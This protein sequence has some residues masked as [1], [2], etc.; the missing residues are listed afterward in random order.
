[1]DYVSSSSSSPSPVSPTR[2]AALKRSSRSERFKALLL[3]KGGRADFSSRI[4]A[5]ERLRLVPSPD[6]PQVKP[7]SDARASKGHLTV[8]VP[9]SPTSLCNQGLMLQWKRADPTPHH[10]LFTSSSSSPFLFLSPSSV[11]PRSLTPPCSASR[12]FAARCRLYAAPMTAIFEAQSE[13]EGGEWD[14][15]VFTG[16]RTEQLRFLDGWGKVLM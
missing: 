3:R 4:S 1:M 5:V 15:E 8:D 13:E 7:V 11:R 14:G 2:P 9:T 12:R 6:Q 10:L 16:N